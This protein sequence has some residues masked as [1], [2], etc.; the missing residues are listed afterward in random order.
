MSSP[1]EAYLRFFHSE[2]PGGFEP[3]ADGS[4]S[5]SM[6]G[7]PR[8]L[9]ARVDRVQIS[10]TARKALEEDEAREPGPAPKR[11]SNP[12]SRGDDGADRALL[13]LYL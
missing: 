13:D 9:D 11:S 12:G 2:I 8:T 6:I 1:L 5:I 7:S 4:E 10:D 3:R